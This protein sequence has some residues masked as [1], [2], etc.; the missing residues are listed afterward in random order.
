MKKEVKRL[1]TK[2]EVKLMIEISKELLELNYKIT[3]N[4]NKE[5][6]QVRKFHKLEKENRIDESKIAWSEF[7]ET[8]NH[9][10]FLD[11]HKAGL[12]SVIRLIKNKTTFEGL[13]KS[14][15]FWDYQIQFDE[16]NSDIF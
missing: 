8:C 15:E 14:R 12:Q 16:V 9:G 10:R 5:Q 4:K 11:G 2:E 7:R 1:L 13:K 6:R 3:A